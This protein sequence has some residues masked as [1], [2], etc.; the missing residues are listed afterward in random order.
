M[1]VAA[2]VSELPGEGGGPVAYSDGAP[3]RDPQVRQFLVGEKLQQAA[4][5]VGVS[6]HSQQQLLV[7]RVGLLKSP[8]MPDMRSGGILDDPLAS[9]K[10]LKSEDYAVDV[11]DD[12]VR[13][14]LGGPDTPHSPEF[15]RKAFCVPEGWS[16]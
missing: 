10:G 6:A 7:G 2:P 13:E 1:G 4:K 15:N 16:L 5:S 3:Q 11:R 12:R 14:P 9:W 8:G